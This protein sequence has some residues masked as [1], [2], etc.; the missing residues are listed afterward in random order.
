MNVHE[1]DARLEKIKSIKDEHERSNALDSVVTAISSLRGKHS[2]SRWDAA[3]NVIN[4]FTDT[5]HLSF[6]LGRLAHQLE[7]LK[8][9]DRLPRLERVEKRV[10]GFSNDDYYLT[11]LVFEGLAKGGVK[12]LKGF[13]VIQIDRFERYSA[14]AKERLSSDPLLLGCAILRLGEALPALPE[15]VR[16]RCYDDLDELAK[17]HLRNDSESYSIAIEGL[18]AGLASLPL[19]DVPV[20]R[21]D[22]R[23]QAYSLV[24]TFDRNITLGSIDR[25]HAA[26]INRSIEQQT[27]SLR[28]GPIDQFR[29]KFPRVAKQMDRVKKGLGMR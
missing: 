22:L 29:A 15:P 8:P 14:R 28:R 13:G 9:P 1:F 23:Q 16:T 2:A 17:S 25:G 27:E 24:D 19:A 6:Q 4:S 5:K 20:R 26:L 11:S 21:K 10:E 12:A 3:F 7:A 18:S